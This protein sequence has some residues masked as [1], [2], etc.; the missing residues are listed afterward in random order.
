M[1]K[2]K[3]SERTVEVAPGET[4]NE[5]IETM[6]SRRRNWIEVLVDP[7]TLQGLMLCGGGLLVVG[8]VVWLWSI[9][10]FENKLVVATCLGA[11]NAALL[12]LGVCGA[13]FSRY[14]TASKAITMLACL[15]MPLNLWFYDAQG[16]ITLDEGGHLW[17][18]AL[19]CCALY[20][21]VAR[22]LADPLFVNAIVGGVTMTGLLILADHQVGRLW[23]I[24]APSSFL[25]VLG[26]ICIHI[27]RAFPPEKGSFSRANFGRAFFHAGHV[28]MGLGLVVLLVG[29]LAG[30]LYEPFF[31]PVRLVCHPSGS[32]AGQFAATCAG[33][34]TWSGVLVCLFTTRRTG[35]RPL[36]GICRADLDLVGY[37]TLRLAE[38][39]VHYGVGDVVDCIGFPAGQWRAGFPATCR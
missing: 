27:E 30:R 28:V 25:V 6:S 3:D 14:Q 23:E 29:R 22:V 16:L 31:F 5:N 19:V 24:M 1:D 12:A 39:R 7:Q 34:G 11:G 18:P 32:D 13:R 10:V 8:L 21:V 2:E 33:I 35:Q 37:P 17:V 9:G 26:M 36:S 20:V 38:C 4:L 15:V